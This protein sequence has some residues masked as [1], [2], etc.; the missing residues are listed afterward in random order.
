MSE[1]NDVI[2]EEEGADEAPSLQKIKEKLAECRKEREEYLDGW[3]RA[4]ADFVNLKKEEAAR[5]ESVRADSEVLLAEKLIPL[6]DSFEMGLLLGTKEDKGFREGMDAVYK[7]FLKLLKELDVSSF[8]PLG[9]HFD[10]SL[11]I[12]I[13]QGEGES[14][15]ILKTE[16]KGYKKGER[17]LRPAY[18]IIGR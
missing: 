5:R 9:E 7:E 2:L 18:V 12:P 1:E 17:I 15:K 3:Q 8:D 16:R 6:V 4:R 14:G 11:H 13:S 10:P